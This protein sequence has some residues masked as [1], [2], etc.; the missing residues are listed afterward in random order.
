MFFSSFSLTLPSPSLAL[1]SPLISFGLSRS[2]A[3]A[4]HAPSLTLPSCFQ[5]CLSAGLLN[6]RPAWFHFWK[7]LCFVFS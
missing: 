5:S 3:G 1:I 7:R 4:G 6:V 2:Q